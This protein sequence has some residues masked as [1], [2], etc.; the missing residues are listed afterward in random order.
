MTIGMAR[1]AQGPYNVAIGIENA[2]FGNG[3]GGK[4]FLE[5]R[6][7]QQALRRKGGRRGAML[8][9]KDRRQFSFH[10]PAWRWLRPALFRKVSSPIRR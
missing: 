2:D 4:A 6:F 1:D 7:A 3:G 10:S 8:M 9:R 5:A